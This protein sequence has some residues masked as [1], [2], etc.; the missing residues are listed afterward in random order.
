M[1]QLS[2]LEKSFTVHL[3]E[4]RDIVITRAAR[5]VIVS[6]D[7]LKSSKLCAGDVVAIS[8]VDV[9][10]DSEQQVGYQERSLFVS[11]GLIAFVPGFRFTLW[12]LYGL[13]P[14]SNRI[15]VSAVKI[16]TYSPFPPTSPSR[17]SCVR[18]TLAP[19][20]CQ[21]H[22][23]QQNSHHSIVSTKCALWLSINPARSRSRDCPSRRVEHES[24]AVRFTQPTQRLTTPRQTARLAHSARERITRSPE[25]SIPEAFI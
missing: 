17:C 3:A 9:T 2:L 16:R 14:R 19:S 24:Y 23:W 18:L 11:V 20:I 13:R 21:T 10:S 7:V 5:R 12:G 25:K 1:S 6:S 4:P 15:A 22:G 8:N